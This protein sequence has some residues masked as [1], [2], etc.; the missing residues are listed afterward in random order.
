MYI[1][2]HSKYYTG[3]MW[4]ERNVHHIT[5]PHHQH[6]ELIQRTLKRLLGKDLECSSDEQS[7]TQPVR[8]TPSITGIK[9][10]IT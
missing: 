4:H 6:F 5:Y 7:V 2:T 3:S 10:D 9:Y 1:T 8:R